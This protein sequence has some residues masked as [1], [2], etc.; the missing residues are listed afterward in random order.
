MWVDILTE[1]SL[2]GGGAKQFIVW[3]ASVVQL[4]LFKLGSV[5][6][7]KQI[8]LILVLLLHIN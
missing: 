2:N 6:I 3:L 7:L 1:S 5:E 4:R 8:I